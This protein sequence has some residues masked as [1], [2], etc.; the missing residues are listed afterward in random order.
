LKR[1]IDD[2]ISLPSDKLIELRAYSLYFGNFFANAIILVI[3]PSMYMI[4]E[5]VV[6]KVKGE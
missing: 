3:E 6:G 4:L 1:R 2:L 5:D